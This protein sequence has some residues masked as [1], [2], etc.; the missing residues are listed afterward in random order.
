MPT[1]PSKQIRL[2]TTPKSFSSRRKDSVS[3]QLSTNQSQS[4][5]SL[6]TINGRQ[7]LNCTSGSNNYGINTLK[8]NNNN[9]RGSSQK[10]K[11]LKKNFSLKKQNRVESQNF[12]QRQAS[13]EISDKE[14]YLGG[15]T[16]DTSSEYDQ[17]PKVSSQIISKPALIIKENSD[18]L[19]QNFRDEYQS[20]INMNECTRSLLV[21]QD[22]NLQKRELSQIKDDKCG[23]VNL[24]NKKQS[25]DFSQSKNKKSL[26]KEN[27][28]NR[29][30]GK[31][32]KVSLFSQSKP[33]SV[34]ESRISNHMTAPSESKIST[35]IN[36][37]DNNQPI[38]NDQVPSN[39][40]PSI[41]DYLI[42]PKRLSTQN[43]EKILFSPPVEKI[44]KTN[45]F[46]KQKYHSNS[47][48][49]N[50]SHI[51]NNSQN[52]RTPTYREDRSS[53]H[54][55]DQKLKKTISRYE[56]PIKKLVNQ[57][58][59]KKQVNQS[60]QKQ[61]E[62]KTLFSENPSLK[63]L[64]NFY[65][66]NQQDMCNIAQIGD[67]TQE[68]ID[69]LQDNLT[70]ILEQTTE[71]TNILSKVQTQNLLDSYRP[72][73][74]DQIQ[75]SDADSQMYFTVD[76]SKR[77]QL[78]I[79]K[80]HQSKELKVS[81]SKQQYAQS[82]STTIVSKTVKNSTSTTTKKQIFEFS[83]NTTKTNST[84]PKQN[85]IQ[86]TI[87]TKVTNYKQGS[88]SQSRSNSSRNEKCVSPKSNTMNSKVIQKDDRD[89]T[90]SRKVAVSVVTP[91]KSIVIRKQSR[92]IEIHSIKKIK[93]DRIEKQ[94]DAQEQFVNDTIQKEDIQSQIIMQQE[95][96]NQQET[97]EQQPRPRSY[98]PDRNESVSPQSMIVSS[99]LQGKVQNLENIE[100]QTQEGF[101]NNQS[102]LDEQ[103]LQN[104]LA[105]IQ[106]RNT[107][108]SSPLKLIEDE[109]SI[110]IMKYEEILKKLVGQYTKLQKNHIELQGKSQSQEQYWQQQHTNLQTQ[111]QVISQENQQ[112]KHQLQNEYQSKQYDRQQFEKFKHSVVL[113]VQRY[114]ECEIA[115]K[116]KIQMLT[117]EKQAY[118]KA[119][120]NFKDQ[121]LGAETEKHSL[122]NDIKRV[123]SCLDQY[124]AEN[125]RIKQTNQIF[126]KKQQEYK[127]TAEQ[128]Q[129]QSHQKDLICQQ[130]QNENHQI[131]QIL[132]NLKVQLDQQ[133]RQNSQLKD[134]ISQLLIDKQQISLKLLQC[135]NQTQNSK[136][137]MMLS[138][139]NDSTTTPVKQKSINSQPLVFGLDQS[140][141]YYSTDNKSNAMSSQQIQS[142]KQ[143]NS[144]YNNNGLNTTNLS[145]NIYYTPN[146]NNMNQT[147]KS[148]VLGGNPTPLKE[149]ITPKS[150]ERKYITND[151]SSVNQVM[152]WKNEQLQHYANYGIMRT[153]KATTIQ[154]SKIDLSLPST[155]IKPNYIDQNC[156]NQD[157]LDHLPAAGK[158]SKDIHKIKHK[159]F[160]SYSNQFINGS[161]NQSVG[162]LYS[163]QSN[164]LYQDL[165]GRDFDYQPFHLNSYRVTEPQSNL[166]N[167][168]TFNQ[169]NNDNLIG[170]F[171]TLRSTQQEFRDIDQL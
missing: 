119:M 166:L 38:T 72:G 22:Q 109:R 120:K 59:L 86:A 65:C 28:S 20:Q 99:N 6:N 116:N 158:D 31:V 88:G 141:N 156:L 123:K 170:T 49:G 126:D 165:A 148:C 97:K 5:V 8:S 47:K 78:E 113:D 142:F 81:T 50:F 16:T 144:N 26:L 17:F 71:N 121:L 75:I 25:Q 150:I 53:T 100:I 39:L 2:S 124:E 70:K 95:L 29:K 1:V 68:Q 12:R 152:N 139:A 106:N 133:V 114:Q 73:S 117:D 79:F 146:S 138:F 168:L 112:L 7:I 118:E 56:D 140:K 36:E 143:L 60:Q 42:S 129:Q 27:N 76:K 46:D 85:Q 92:E 155:A 131:K 4:V 94:E 110:A 125:I 18:N 154:R 10:K 160:N 137:P 161:H 132:E 66:Q 3:D 169:N 91:M 101:Q 163:S 115:F 96:Q 63:S 64:E 35:N 24:R 89:T 21:P 48:S 162:N 77:S 134:D 58:K 157:M 102:R 104:A 37:I 32:T 57:Q 136:Q 171:D 15:M 19:Q 80:K 164:N 69:Y 11:Q 74:S 128:L 149:R 44:T 145:G 90:P 167:G 82:I 54:E 84:L 147:F 127:H 55:L 62:E 111:Y 67:D 83:N 45:P 52:R 130:F 34:K 43:S 87:N 93:L 108:L 107:S 103:E 13:T 151:S 105:S 14:R 122:E 9:E 51:N 61:L 40:S 153:P 41:N 159:H 98:S 33:N 135:Q 30:G 23:V